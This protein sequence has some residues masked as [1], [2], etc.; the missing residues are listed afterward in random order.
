MRPNE[1]KRNRINVVEVSE[2]CVVA[3]LL[4]AIGKPR[5]CKAIFRLDGDTLLYSGSYKVRPT[6][7]DDGSGYKVV[8]KRVTKASPDKR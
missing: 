1:F 2:N 6:G 3:D 4:V 5:T 8:W 7:F